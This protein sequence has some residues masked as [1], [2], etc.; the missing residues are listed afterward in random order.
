VLKHRNIVHTTGAFFSLSLELFRYA[1]LTLTLMNIEK[2]FLQ[3]PFSTLLK[4]KNMNPIFKALLKK[5][6]P[7]TYKKESVKESN[8]EPI[9]CSSAPLSYFSTSANCTKTHS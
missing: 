4:L 1:V 7:L 2:G 9:A 3:N 6:F 8:P 5:R